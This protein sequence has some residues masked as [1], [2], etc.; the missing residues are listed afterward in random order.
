MRVLVDNEASV[1]ILF[2]DTFIRMG[3]NDFKLT[4]SIAPIYGF[5]H[6]EC[7]VEG[8]IQ[9]LV[10]I[11]EEPRE[12]TQMLNFQVVK[13]ASTYNTIMGR[14]GIQA[15]KFVPSTYH[16]VLKFL[17]RNGVGEAKRDQK[18][19][20]SC[21]VVALRPDGTGGQVLPIKDMHVRKKDEL[22]GKPT[23][24]LVPIPLDKPL[25]GQLITFLQKN[26]DVFSWTTTDMPWIEPDLITHRLNIDTTRKDVK[27]K[28]RTYALDRVE[29]IKQEA[30]KLLEAGFIEE[31]QFPEWLANPVIV[32]KANRKWRMCIDFTD[33]NDTCPK[34]CYPLPRLDTLIDATTGHKILSFMDGF[35]GYN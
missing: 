11:E 21:S 34:D 14:K 22:R 29:A 33:L 3:Y 16:M 15:F 28:K 26:S 25:K 7:K 30:E 9:L 19:A 24:D 35:S 4:P 5:N 18:M 17:T 8:E 6:V 20:R 27:K 32:K 12:A 31:V 10:T 13:S 2:H 1:D 23:E